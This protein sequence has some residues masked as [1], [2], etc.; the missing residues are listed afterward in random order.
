MESRG[1]GFN[2][3]TVVD[4][5]PELLLTPEVALGRLDR[6][7]PKDELDLVQFAA[8]EVAQPR[9]CPSLM[10]GPALATS[11]RLASYAGSATGEF[12]WARYGHR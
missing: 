3:Q 7:V 1:I 9:A 5:V 10:P 2:A 12:R 6:D 8:G 4:G 11:C